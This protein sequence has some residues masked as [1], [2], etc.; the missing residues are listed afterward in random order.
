MNLRLLGVALTR[1]ALM[2]LDTPSGVVPHHRFPESLRLQSQ[3]IPYDLQPRPLAY[4]GH[5]IDVILRI[6]FAARPPLVG[7]HFKGARL[8]HG[9]F[10][11]NELLPAILRKRS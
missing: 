10:H 2:T 5:A 3:D 4:L 9:G 7:R 6:V 11:F 1:F 8:S